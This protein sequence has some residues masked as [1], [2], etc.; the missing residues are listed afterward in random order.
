MSLY[1]DMKGARVISIAS[2]RG[3]GATTRSA[4]S[5]FG[6]GLSDRAMKKLS[7]KFGKPV[8]ET[9]FRNRALFLVM[10]STGLRAK[11]IL[12][13]KFTDKIESPEGDILFRYLRKGGNLAFAVISGEA[14]G[15]VK[16]YHETF[17]IESDH[18]FVT[19][20]VNRT[21]GR[22]MPMTTRQLGR[23]VNGWNVTTGTGRPVHPHAF[24]HTVGQKMFD[25]YGSMA[26]QKKLGHTSPVITSKYYTR[27][28]YDGTDVLKW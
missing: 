1:R 16:K 20:P 7:K 4:G 13:L 2:R 24:R 3:A 5:M 22:R 23:I 17:G 21:K 11:E 15:S 26:A 28:Y 10:S 25:V 18:F 12:S 19:L 27:P 14:L 9:D 8:S 6:K